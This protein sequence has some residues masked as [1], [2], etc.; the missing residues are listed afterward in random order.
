MGITRVI[1]KP[2]HAADLA[3]AVRDALEAR[4]TP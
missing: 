2:Y 4:T 1:A 3:R